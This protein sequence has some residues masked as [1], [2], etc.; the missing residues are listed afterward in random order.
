MCPL[1]NSQEQAPTYEQDKRELNG[2]TYKGSQVLN[3]G[4]VLIPCPQQ[5]MFISR[6]DGQYD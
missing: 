4:N 1:R 5:N 3:D 2:I 6:H